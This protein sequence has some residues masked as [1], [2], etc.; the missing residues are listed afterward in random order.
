M[1][2]RAVPRHLGSTNALLGGHIDLV[3]DA[4]GWAPLVYGG[5]LRLLV[6]WSDKRSKNWPK[7][8]TLEG[9]R[10]AMVSNRR[11]PGRPKGMNPKVVKSCTT[12]SRRAAKSRLHLETL[13]RLDQEPF[14]LTPPDYRAFASGRSPS[15]SN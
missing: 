9:G 5:R 14:Y 13:T 4:S 12:R 3:A 10:I 2:P 7:L 1:D 11:S 8:P 6:I 15:R